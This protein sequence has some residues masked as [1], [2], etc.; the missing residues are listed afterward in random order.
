MALIKS[1]RGFTPKIGDGVFLADNATVIG[2]VEIGDRSSIWFNAVLRGDV[3][4]IRIGR[5]VNVQDGA[6]LHTLYEK[7]VIEIGD[8]VSIGHNVTIHG[9]KIERNALIGMGATVLDHAVVGEGA[10]V[11]AGSVVLSRTQIEPY[12]V[13]AGVPARFVKKVDPEQSKELNQRIA[14]NYGM[15]ASWYIN[16]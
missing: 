12:S 9:A 3:N 7:S 1:V 5:N 6:V 13:Y 11:A 16:E 10:V 4:S 8:D 14:A 2:D 15:Y